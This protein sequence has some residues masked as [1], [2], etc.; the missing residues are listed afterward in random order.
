MQ[1]LDTKIKDVKIIQPK[2][3]GD[4]RGF[5]LETFERNRYRDMLNLDL[6]FVQ[7]NHSRSSKGVLRGLHFQKHNPQGKLVRVVRGTVFDVAV[8]IRKDSPTFGEW[9]GVILSEDNKTQFWI[10]PGLAHGFVVISDIADFEYKCTDYYTPENER[11]L[12]WNDPDIGIDWPIDKPLL[13]EKDKAGKRLT[14][15]FE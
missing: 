7:D 13:S 12:I 14:E 9:Q 15:L 11:C 6:D 1:V 10:P 8:D 3:F 2:V 4:A 5:F